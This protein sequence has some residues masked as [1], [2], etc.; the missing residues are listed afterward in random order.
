MKHLVL[1]T[2]I[3]TLN[4]LG[5]GGLK[6]GSIVMPYGEPGSG[7]STFCYQT[8]GLFHKDNPDAMVHIIDVENSVDVN[9]LKYV[10]NLDMDRVMVH[11]TPTLEGA[12]KLFLDICTN[13]S[14]QQIGSYQNGRKKVKILSKKQVF[15]MEDKE[16]FSYCE[17]FSI[18]TPN[19]KQDSKPIRAKDY[20][21]DREKVLKA[22]GLACGYT[23]KEYGGPLPTLVVWDTIAVSR[24]Q[25]ELDKVAE[26]NMDK[27]AAG[28]N[29]AAQVISTKLS[30][31]L[32]S[33]G[34]K[35]LTLFLPNQVRNKA[36]GFMGGFKEGYSG[37]WAVGHNAHYILKFTKR[38]NRD[39]RAKNFDEDKQLKTGT[40]FFM[41][42][43]KTKF[44]PATGTVDLY[45]NDAKGGL[46]IPMDEL[47]NTAKSLGYITTVHGGFNIPSL[48]E[49]K[50]K[51]TRQ[52]DSTNYISG[53]PKVRKHL[54]GEITR[55]Y[56][57]SYLTLNIVYE[58]VG[59]DH[60]G[61]PTEEEIAEAVG[62]HD[63]E[64]LEDCFDNPFT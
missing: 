1:R 54:I 19:P 51:W 18:P 17:Q 41:R 27:N 40:D 5:A 14:Y 16:L 8:A 44:C 33:M 59:L 63:A 6:S 39:S 4:I 60:I 12:F 47:A 22:L 64:F 13:M 10:F 62:H 23:L 55:H 28:M 20:D 61:K 38:D 49:T 2:P 36:D 21:N 56:R 15:E 50:Y 35:P 32:S 42:I 58:Q 53:N 25:A 57:K 45:I 48:D 3:D 37:G 31:C 26:G 29:V 34:A 52:E 30:A 24:P 46:I 7:K 11:Y 9:R 43:E